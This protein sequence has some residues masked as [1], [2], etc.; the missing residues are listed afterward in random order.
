VQKKLE[1]FL[2]G[3]QHPMCL[4]LQVNE[5]E[6]IL[7]AVETAAV[8][9]TVLDFILANPPSNIS[10]VGREIQAWKVS[11]DDHPRQYRAPSG[12]PSVQPGQH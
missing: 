5:V 2:K 3:R 6:S 7:R 11:D 10:V 12:V 9:G 4:I 8:Q 1:I